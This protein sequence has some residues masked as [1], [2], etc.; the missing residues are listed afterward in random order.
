MEF[1]TWGWPFREQVIS[2]AGID[3][4]AEE[5]DG[6]YC[7][8]RLI[9]L[10]IKAGAAYF[11]EP[12]VGGWLFRGTNAQLMYWLGHSLPVVL[13]VQ[14]PETGVT[15]WAHVT[16]PARPVRGRPWKADGAHRPS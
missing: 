3:A 14:H 2:D 4:L 13:L 5:A 10:V 16:R 12:V 15:Y 6:G 11:A 7:S 1:S 8:G 9:A